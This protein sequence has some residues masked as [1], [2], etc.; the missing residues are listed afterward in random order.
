MECVIDPSVSL[1]NE[2]I[3]EKDNNIDLT[4]VNYICINN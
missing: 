3:Q 2:T 1:N 4:L